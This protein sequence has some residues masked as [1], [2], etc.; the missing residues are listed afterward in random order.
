MTENQY[1]TIIIGSGLGGL[2]CGYM[3]SREGMRVCIIEKNKQIG[4][5][6]QTFR[7]KGF[8]FDTGIHYLG[9][10]DEGQILHR[11]FNY[12]GL[13]GKLKLSRMNMDRFDVIAYDDAEYPMAQGFDNFIDQLLPFFPDQKGS[14]QSYVE[15][16]ETISKS[17]PLYNLESPKTTHA[18][19]IYRHQSAYHYYQSLCKK[20]S[21]SAVS[22]RQSYSILDPRASIFDPQ[23]SLSSVLAGNNFLYAGNKEKTPLHIAALINHSFISS[24]WKTIGGSRQIADLLIESILSFGGVVRTNCEVTGILHEST[25]F[26][27]V[28]NSDEQFSCNRLLSGIHP[29]RTIE[30]MDPSLFRNVYSSRIRNL[31]NTTGS[32]AVYIV[33]KTNTFKYLDFNY[34]FHKT[35]NVW[36]ESG[37]GL[38]PDGYMLYTPASEEKSNFAKSLVI[39]TYMDYKEVEKWE[40]SYTGKREDGYYEFKKERA[41][42]LIDLAEKQFPGL[43]SKINFIETST[44]LTWRDYTGTPG[45]S[46]YGI[47]KDFHNPLGTSVL[48]KTKVPGLFFTGQNVNLHGAL[49]VTIGSVMTCSEILGYDY[50]IKKICNG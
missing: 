12:F 30:M 47:Q 13:T 28:T 10:L 17:F 29:A 15:T 46:M 50:M 48:P 16:L 44:P 21:Q 27:A 39:M 49:G 14:L 23:V 34:Y 26:K 40:K 42:Q 3:L 31:A 36:H 22:S 20:S 43:R 35:K 19:E 8:D 45:G 18:E 24:A 4:G 5:A 38:W 1:D 37:K 33:L 11:Y 41:N 9:G 25:G 6:L 32:F 2:L 7:R